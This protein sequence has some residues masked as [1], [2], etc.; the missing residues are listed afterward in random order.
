[1]SENY[2][3]LTGEHAAE[4]YLVSRVATVLERTY[5]TRA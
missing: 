4:A 5:R 2:R 1:M 3:I